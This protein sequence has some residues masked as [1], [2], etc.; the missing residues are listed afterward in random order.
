MESL[1]ISNTT[2][3]VDTGNMKGALDTHLSVLTTMQLMQPDV[4]SVFLDELIHGVAHLIACFSVT[5]ALLIC[6]AAILLSCLCLFELVVQCVNELMIYLKTFKEVEEI[7][8][9]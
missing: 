1:T 3:F 2:H 9:F 4:F 7:G 8:I 6:M 5:I